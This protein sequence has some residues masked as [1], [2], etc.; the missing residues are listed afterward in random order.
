MASK[1]T[2]ALSTEDIKELNSANN[3]SFIVN[4]FKYD[5]K[6]EGTVQ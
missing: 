6:V 3:H 1:E 2:E 4:I 5:Q